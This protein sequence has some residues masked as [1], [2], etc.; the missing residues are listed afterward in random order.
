MNVCL[1][2]KNKYEAF[3]CFSRPIRTI[4]FQPI[5][6][7]PFLLFTLSDRD[8]CWAQTYS[9]LTAISSTNF[10]KLSRWSQQHKYLNYLMQTY[11]ALEM[12]FFIGDEMVDAFESDQDCEHQIAILTVIMN[13]L[14]VLV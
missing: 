13:I 11:I 14:G 6:P 5:Q 8:I 2:A 10:L 9:H 4:S 12:Q 7:V 1:C 3:V